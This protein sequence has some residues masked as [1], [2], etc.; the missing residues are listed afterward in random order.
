MPAARLPATAGGQSHGG[1]PR[2]PSYCRRRS[3]RHAPQDAC[4]TA[5]SARHA[6]KCGRSRRGP[7]PRSPS[8]RTPDVA[9]SVGS[10][11]TPAAVAA[12]RNAIADGRYWIGPG[13]RRSRWR[14]L[15]FN[16][17]VALFTKGIR[18]TPLYERGRQNALNLGVFE[19]EVTLPELPPK[20]AGCRIL[21]VSDTHLDAFPEL[22]DA[23]RQLLDGVQVDVLMLTGDVQG[24]PRAPAALSAGLLAQALSGV[25][26]R[27]PHL[28]V[29]GNHDSVTMVEALET[30]DFEVLINRSIILERDDERLRIT[31]LDDVH[32]FYTVAALTALREHE[33]KC[34]IA[35][36]HSPEMADHADAAGYAVFVRPH[37]RRADFAC[38]VAGR[39]CP[40]LRDAATQPPACGATGK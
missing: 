19:F 5:L 10:S 1:L 35:L 29:L 26:V 13:G 21:H 24:D 25:S 8:R 3:R 31:G 16:G 20:F 4:K 33:D 12:V 38:R 40:S 22:A 6:F 36:V 2:D 39:S 15:L 32:C 7:W 11:L 23:T 28:A 18:L 9:P 37:S 17:L 14:K 34:R 27:G 30:L